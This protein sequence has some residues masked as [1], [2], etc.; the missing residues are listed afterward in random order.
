MLLA[1]MKQYILYIGGTLLVVGALLPLFAPQIAPW[2][3]AIGAL[4]FTP[5]QIMDRYEGRNLII[6]HLRRQQ[7]IGALLLVVSAAMMFMAVYQIPPC[8]GG[9]WKITLFIA[10]V[11]EVYTVFRIDKETSK[12]ANKK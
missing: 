2:I 3:Y 10:M 9:E 4:L 11:F 1:N 7:I 6:R 5:I 12:E 8:R